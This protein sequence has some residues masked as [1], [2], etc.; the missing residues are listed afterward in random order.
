ME[1]GEA[2]Q[3]K[4]EPR[5]RQRPCNRSRM[6]SQIAECECCDC[7]RSTGIREDEGESD[8]NSRA[9]KQGRLQVR[10]PHKAQRVKVTEAKVS[11]EISF[12]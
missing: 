7:K 3:E 9:H 10:I 8:L 11:N 6:S 1:S 4:Q 12:T 5:T 2:G